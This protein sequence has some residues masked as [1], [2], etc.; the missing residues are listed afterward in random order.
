MQ[1]IT[2]TVPPSPAIIVQDDDHPQF[3]DRYFIGPMPTLAAKRT[4]EE[5][6]ASDV[7]QHWWLGVKRDAEEADD[8]DNLL[9]ESD[10]LERDAFRYFI[11]EGGREEDW[12]SQ[13]RLRRSVKREILHKWR[14][15]GWS[16]LKH[17][18]NGQKEPR[19]WVGQSFKIGE[20]FLGVPIKTG[21]PVTPSQRSYHKSPSELPVSQHQP[22]EGD[23]GA[24]SIPITS[25][26]YLATLE[27]PSEARSVTSV[28][29]SGPDNRNS[30]SHG[31]E[32]ALIPSSEPPAANNVFPSPLS[33]GR[34]SVTLQKV[35][36]E[37]AG[38]RRLKASATSETLLPPSVPLQ[39]LETTPPSEVLARSAADAPGTSAAAA[40]VQIPGHMNGRPDV[41]LPF[42]EVVR[43]ERMLVRRCNSRIG[44]VGKH[45][46][47]EEA[48][49]LRDLRS[50][51]WKE[52]LVVW[53]GT[54]IELYE[55]YTIPGKEKLLGHKCLTCAIPLQKPDTN[56]SLYSFVDFTFCLTCTMLHV[57]KGR[58][59]TTSNLGDRI[60]SR[61]MSGTDIFIF[62]AKTRTSGIDWMWELWRQLGNVVPNSI[63]VHCPVT[64]SRV[65]LQVPEHDATGREGYKVFTREN[66]ISTCRASL[67]NLPSW[68]YLIDP[69]LEKGLHLQL[70][71]RKETMLDWIRW[72]TSIDGT[73]RGWAVVYGLCLG[74]P[75]EVTHLELRVGEHRPT[76]SKLNDGTKLRE[77]QAV[78]G[79]LYRI[80]PKSHN[81]VHIYLSTHSG[82]L[83]SIYHSRAHPPQPP[84]PWQE[85]KL[86]NNDEGVDDL[87]L[88]RDHEIRRAGAQ[89][90]L[91]AEAFIDLRSIIAVRRAFQ[92]KIPRYDEITSQVI[93][94]AG[95][96]RNA[97]IMSADEEDEGGDEALSYHADK[98]SLRVRRSFELLMKTGGVVR[99]E[100]YSCAVAK[101]W[102]ERLDGLVKYWACRHRIDASQ[103]MEILRATG[104]SPGHLMAR[105]SD[106]VVPR[107]PPDYDEA[108]QMFPAFWNWCVMDECQSVVRN[109][110]LFLRRGLRGQYRLMQLILLPGHLIQ[111]HIESGSVSHHLRSRTISLLD[112]YVC[113][114]H[115]ATQSL[116]VDEFSTTQPP[117]PR[118][119]QDGLEIK[120]YELDTMFL[121]WWVMMIY[122]SGLFL[123]NYRYRPHSI[124]KTNTD[125]SGPPVLTLN[126][127]HKILVLKARSKLERDAWC[128]ALNAVIERLAR[129]TRDRETKGRD[130]GLVN[131]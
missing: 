110:R 119:F 77:P 118:R 34:S 26:R 75:R 44:T 54:R 120:D 5:A 126:A 87:S 70:C 46:S 97:D 131:L 61:R 71:W 9:D 19:K 95:L 43:R 51:D 49:K 121:I 59:R 57:P 103:E 65:D 129:K 47:E 23:S 13:D 30:G 68:K 38:S 106:Q 112:A 40:E 99:F 69:K 4:I 35:N 67:A 105:V 22:P 111:F 32:V 107:R 11:H 16:S 116:S 28:S 6:K 8:D 122:F 114:G 2:T 62:K 7:R 20:D 55:D 74:R 109:G 60:H 124:G 82:C 48:A 90:V 117:L 102:V 86:E 52:F 39:Q 1:P 12:G 108:S 10:V 98:A 88:L 101:E 104:G 31:S 56:I 130:G 25:Q 115:Y 84:L 83:F 14:Q 36:A 76:S 72:E 53:R 15:S 41:P 89:Q 91:Q 42:G 80:K 29:S 78:E 100:T 128:W 18:K 94:D 64:E 81:R 93:V 66:V 24:P 45:F 127:K 33:P 125:S 113:S 79:Y 96:Q 123:M 21:I 50:Y 17:G 73:E 37:S 27:V 63:E 85:S 92:H 3:P 58:G